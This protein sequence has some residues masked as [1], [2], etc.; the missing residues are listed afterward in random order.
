M[1]RL[2]TTTED[3]IVTCIID[4]PVHSV[5]ELH[6]TIEGIA[7]IKGVDEVRRVKLEKRK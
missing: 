7:A 4:F 6:L 1:S 5:E 3:E 2:T